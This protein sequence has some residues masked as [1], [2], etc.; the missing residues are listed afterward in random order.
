MK[1]IH[2][3][4]APGKHVRLPTPSFAHTITCHITKLNDVTDFLHKLATLEECQCGT[5][6]LKASNQRDIN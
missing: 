2:N 1:L 5:D 3:I 4:G 6:T